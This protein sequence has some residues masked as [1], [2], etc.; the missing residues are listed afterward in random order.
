M[1]QRHKG[2]RKYVPVRITEEIDIDSIAR[3][4]GYSATGQFVA[5]LVLADAGRH[6][7][8]EGPDRS[9]EDALPLSA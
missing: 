8:M 7:L 4:R 1:A 6:D 9:K 5:D 2:K 3:D